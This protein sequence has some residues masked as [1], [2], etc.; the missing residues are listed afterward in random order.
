M[1][2]N[3]PAFAVFVVVGNDKKRWIEVGAAWRHKDGEGFNI[4]LDA[5]PPDGRLVLRPAGKPA[6]Q[7]SPK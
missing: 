1:S 7:A 4:T 2:N 6:E 3:T 5:L